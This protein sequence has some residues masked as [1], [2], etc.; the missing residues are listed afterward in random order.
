ME[1]LDATLGRAPDGSNGSELQSAAGVALKP[2][3]K[4]RDTQIFQA[5]AT[6]R[7]GL[8]RLISPTEQSC[9]D[10]TA[11]QASAAT[12]GAWMLD[13]DASSGKPR[14]TAAK[15]LLDDTGTGVY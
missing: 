12:L 2:K 3:G 13:D 8:D 4:A 6:L 14:A 5:M 7:T 9:G 10:V 1:S 11:L 15:G